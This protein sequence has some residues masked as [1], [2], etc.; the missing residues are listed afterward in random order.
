[1]KFILSKYQI[2]DG[3]TKPLHVKKLQEFKRNLN[4]DVFY[5]QFRLSGLSDIKC[6]GLLDIKCIVHILYE[7]LQLYT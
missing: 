1:M 5:S 2:D 3:F 7:V 4:L 6:I